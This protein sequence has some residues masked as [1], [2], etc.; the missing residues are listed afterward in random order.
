MSKVLLIKPRF[1]GLEFRVITQPMGLLY[2]AA[3]LKRTGHVPR[4]HDCACDYRD[5]VALRKT[6]AEWKPDFIGLSIIVTEIEQTRKIMG[7]IREIM[8]SVPV[9]FGGPWPSANPEVSLK[10]FGADYVVIG[11]GEFVFPQLINAVNKGL[12][13]ESIP[14]TACL[15]NGQVRINQGSYLTEEELNGLPLPALEL[16]NNKLYAQK[17]SFAT[18]GCR[19]YVSIVTSRGC[20]FRCAYCHQTLGKVFRKRSVESVL[21][22]METLK[23]Q[24]G[25]KEFEIIDDCFNLDRERMFAILNGIRSRLGKVNLHFPNGLR[26]DILEPEDMKTFKEAGTVS[27][28]FAIETS[29][30]RLQKMIHK[31]LNIERAVRVI[32][33]SVKEGIYTI[34]FFM[35]G[36]PTETYEEACD[37]VNFAAR[38]SL[39]RT[40]FMLVTPFAGTELA[41]MVAESLKNTNKIS[42]PRYVNYFTNAINISAMSDEQLHKVFRSAY[43]RFF[44]NPRRIA[45]LLMHHPRAFSL[46]GYAVVTL[47]KILPR[48]HNPS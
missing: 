21:D 14:G 42:D 17:P 47:I 28:C 27:A 29:S 26:A 36:F 44:L 23:S 34:G 8:P 1:L 19:P 5:L 9:I 43:R 24:Y 6:I 38:S 12:P 45:G 25:F 20:P 10:S 2:I 33:A 3:V 31:N 41:D 30:P 40:M 37:T 46:P 15:L 11:E 22:E 7:I 4:I 48:R 35:L 39:H 18:V 32:N 16:L 13:T